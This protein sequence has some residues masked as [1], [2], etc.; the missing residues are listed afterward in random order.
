MTDVNSQKEKKYQ[1]RILYQTKVFFEIKKKFNVKEKE[2]LWTSKNH[3]PRCWDQTPLD[4][5]N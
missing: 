2:E 4:F 1:E 5:K 3:E